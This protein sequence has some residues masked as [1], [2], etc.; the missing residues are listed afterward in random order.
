MEFTKNYTKFTDAINV[1]CATHLEGIRTFVSDAHE[2]LSKVDS[3]DAKE[4]LEHEDS[5]LYGFNELMA[6]IDTE[7]ACPRCGHNLMLSDLPQYDYVCPECDENFFEAEVGATYCCDGRDE[8]CLGRVDQREI[9]FIGGIGLCDNCYTKL[10][11]NVPAP[12]LEK[13]CDLCESGDNEAA[14]FL[15]KETE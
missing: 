2:I 11:K 10:T 8:K 4:L 6:K 5:M 15:I 14:E 3:T 12:I 9:H 13:A 7:H 1:L